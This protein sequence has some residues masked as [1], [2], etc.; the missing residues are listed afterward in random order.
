MI[1]IAHRGLING[2]DKNLENN[3]SQI[4]LALNAGFEIEL[5]LWMTD[6]GL[7]LGHDEPQYQ[8]DRDFLDQDKLWIHAKNLAALIWL[9]TTDL[10]YFWHQNDDYIITSHHFIWTFPGNPLSPRS[11]SVMPELADPTLEKIDKTCYG[12]CSDYVAK[13]KKDLI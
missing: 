3:P 1:L 9:T 5:D 7:F 8:V 12:I 2:P 4:E 6:T 11:I 13:I 10:N